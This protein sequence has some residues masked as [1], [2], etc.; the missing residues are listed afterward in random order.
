[1]TGVESK[2]VTFGPYFKVLRMEKRITL[3][4]FCR[5][6]GADPGNI[7]KLERG[8]WPP[9]Q[10]K[11]ILERYARA[12]DLKPATDEWYRF[13][14]YAAAD[15]GIIPQDIMSDEE[16]VKVLPVL[17]RTLR[18]EKPTEEGLNRL[19]TKLKKS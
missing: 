3:R 9:P 11:D 6:A 8:V 15:C 17:F 2:A 10:D 1:M 14:D 16:V 18:R 7:S 19:V 4:E 13:F 5:R 12:L